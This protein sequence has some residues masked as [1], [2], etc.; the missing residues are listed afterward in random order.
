MHPLASATALQHWGNSG[1]LLDMGRLGEPSPVCA[2][3][4]QE[5]GCERG[6]APRQGAKKRGVLVDSEPRGD[7]L[8]ELLDARGQR[9]E[10]PRKRLDQKYTR[11]HDSPIAGEWRRL[12]D[13]LEMSREATLPPM[14]DGIELPERLRPGAL[15]RRQRG[16]A[17]QEFTPEGLPEFLAQPVQDLRE[18]F[19]QRCGELLDQFGPH[20]DQAAARSDQTPEGAGGFVVRHPRA[21]PIPMLRHEFA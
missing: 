4:D 13:R 20:V 1:V 6:P 12:G 11:F 18:V 16:P 10:L 9:L 5:P 8:L 3:G 19:L 17:E 21:E 14:M 7:V 2:E 15:D